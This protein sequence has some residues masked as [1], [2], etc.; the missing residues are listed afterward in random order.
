M[1]RTYWS[2]LILLG[3]VA[4]V[5]YLAMGQFDA[6]CR[7][8]VKFN[9]QV[10]CESARADDIP[11]AQMQATQSACSQLTRNVTESFACPN[12]APVS[13]DCTE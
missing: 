1:N 4:A 7:V 8:C 5:V 12:V 3:F 6:H 10:V 13:L 2:L 9:G 11:A